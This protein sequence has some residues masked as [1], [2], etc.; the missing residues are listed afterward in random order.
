VGKLDALPLL[1]NDRDTLFLLF[2]AHEIRRP[3]RRAKFFAEAARVLANSGQLLL[4]EHLRDWKNFFVFGPGFL[5]FYSRKEWLRVAQSAGLT[6]EREDRL[7]PLV[8]CFL[9]R[10]ARA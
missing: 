5:H 6:I 3:E 4:V 2:A 1:D 8:R 7:T 10:K 9:M